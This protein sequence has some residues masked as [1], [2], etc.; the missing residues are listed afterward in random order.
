MIDTKDLEEKIKL[1]G[2][3]ITPQRKAILKVLL[4]HKGHFLSAEKI[5][6]NTCK[7]HPKLN[8]TTIYRNLE[9]LV[10]INLVHK[11][12]G[13]EGCLYSIISNKTHHH[14]IICKGCGKTEIIDF[15]PIQKFIDLIKDKNF[16][17]TEHKIEL[18]GYCQKCKKNH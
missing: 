3:K 4:N 16:T 7:T 11:I 8:I 13:D 9:I 15:C 10:N 1:N 17:L 12:Q 6:Q 14:H 18:Y 5:H 2:Y